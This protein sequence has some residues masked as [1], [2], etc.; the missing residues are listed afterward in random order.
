MTGQDYSYNRYEDH[1]SSLKKVSLNEVEMAYLDE[2]EG[3]PIVLVHGIPTHSW[4][5]RKMVNPLVR[6]GFRVI[7]PDMIGSG[8]STIPK[9]TSQLSFK[10]HSEHLQALCNHLKLNHATLVVHD[11]GGPWSYHLLNLENHPFDQV[12]LLNTILYTEGFNPPFRPKK[13]GLTHRL[14]TWSYGKKGISRAI[15][16]QTVKQGLDRVKLSKEEIAGYQQGFAAKGKNLAST[17]F[18]SLRQMDAICKVGQKAL[19]NQ[20]TPLLV[21][22]G[23]NDKILV[24]AKQIPLIREHLNLRPENAVLLAGCNHY[25]QEEVPDLI[26]EKITEFVNRYK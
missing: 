23:Q 11:A 16:K 10:A 17:F 1:I 4:L 7:V 3:H 22:W 14:T 25:I 18:G 13:G 19:S 12:V 24:P 21:L 9:D 2:G 5:Y 26:V 6:Q 20:K 8:E 15:I